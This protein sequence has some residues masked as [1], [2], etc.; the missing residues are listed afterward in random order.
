VFLH[1]FG[2]IQALL[3]LG[4][5]IIFCINI[6][7][8]S[9]EPTDPNQFIFVLHGTKHLKKNTVI[10]KISESGNEVNIQIYK[11]DCSSGKNCR[12]PLSTMNLPVSE[13]KDLKKTQTQYEEEKNKTIFTRGQN[14]EII[15]H[16]PIRDRDEE[17]LAPPP[18]QCQNPPSS[19]PQGTPEILR[20]AQSQIEDEKKT[21]NSSS[22]QIELAKDLEMIRQWNN[23]PQN[24]AGTDQINHFYSSYYK[25]DAAYRRS[26]SSHLK[27]RRDWFA[28]QLSGLLK[29]RKMA[30]LHMLHDTAAKKF[31][32]ANSAEA[33]IWAS[34]IIDT[35]TAFGEFRNRVNKDPKNAPAY[36]Y[37]VELSLKIRAKESRFKHRRGIALDPTQPDKLWLQN[38]SGGAA[39]WRAQYSSWNPTDINN[40]YAILF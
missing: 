5:A 13:F 38:Y 32:S 19:K 9:A 6:Q 15:L 28:G 10:Q 29:K 30:L 20:A 34:R 21:K 7:S 11:W 14:G 25:A 24:I 2:K 18:D 35:L 16:H 3:L 22:L 39:L 17:I 40:L 26:G 12:I 1:P 4:L 36:I 33:Q 31:G 37:Y 27:D 8:L 23:S